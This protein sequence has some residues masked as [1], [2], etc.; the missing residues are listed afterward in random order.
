MVFFARIKALQKK[1]NL[2]I[3]TDF[4]L[5][6]NCVMGLPLVLTVTTK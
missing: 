4:R 5:K 1:E 6:E 3:E 2:Y